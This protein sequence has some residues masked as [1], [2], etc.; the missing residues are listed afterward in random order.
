MKEW[1]AAEL[2]ELNIAETASGQYTNI[3]ETT[4]TNDSANPTTSTPSTDDPS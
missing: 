4:T 3:F 2:V 1:K